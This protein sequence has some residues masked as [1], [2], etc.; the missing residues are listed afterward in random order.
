MG[1]VGKGIGRKEGDR[2]YLG[3]HMTGFQMSRHF[4][5]FLGNRNPGE[6]GLAALDGWE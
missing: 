4:C 1:V 6:L 3:N 5:S 2:Q